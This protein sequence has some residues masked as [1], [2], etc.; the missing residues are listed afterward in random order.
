MRRWA[1]LIAVALVCVVALAGCKILRPSERMLVDD[2]IEN[3][4]VIDDELHRDEPDIDGL[5]ELSEQN[6]ENAELLEDWLDD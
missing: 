1:V 2:V 5:R 4:K 6:R 3:S